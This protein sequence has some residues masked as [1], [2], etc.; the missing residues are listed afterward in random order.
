MYG[1]KLLSKEEIQAK[2]DSYIG[3]LELSDRIEIDFKDSIVA[4]CITH[5]DYKKN[6]SKVLIRTPL[7]VRENMIEGIFNHE[8]GTHCIRRYNESGQI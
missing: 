2:G 7:K 1:G 3:N 5:H 4:R 6:Q 8:I